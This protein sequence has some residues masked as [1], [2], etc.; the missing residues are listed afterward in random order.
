VHIHG[1]KGY[2]VDISTHYGMASLSHHVI[3][4]LPNHHMDD[5]GIEIDT[6]LINN[7]SR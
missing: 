6:A 7:E 3:S 1:M 2:V 5:E 4:Q